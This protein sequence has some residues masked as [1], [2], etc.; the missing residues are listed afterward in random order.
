MATS[1]ESTGGIGCA[2]DPE[3]CQPGK[4]FRLSRRKSSRPPCVLSLLK[5]GSARSEHTV[6][7]GDAVSILRCA[8]PKDSRP[9][10]CA[11]QAMQGQQR[12]RCSSPRR[13]FDPQ[14]CGEIEPDSQGFGLLDSTA[15]RNP[16][17]IA[18][19]WR[20]DSVILNRVGRWNCRQQMPA[21]GAP[22]SASRHMRTGTNRGRDNLRRITGSYREPVDR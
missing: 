12:D 7:V 13:T 3:S 20:V 18:R 16:D 11:M 22:V 5:T 21:R 17:K 10:P 1:V 14:G 9:S 4:P 19:R 8:L 2:S 15:D 6:P